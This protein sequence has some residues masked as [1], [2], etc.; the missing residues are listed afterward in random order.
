MFGGYLLLQGWALGMDGAILR[1][2]SGLIMGFLPQ[3]ESIFNQCLWPPFLVKQLNEQ[4]LDRQ[5]LSD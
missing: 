2:K 1:A 5:G 4:V 3:S